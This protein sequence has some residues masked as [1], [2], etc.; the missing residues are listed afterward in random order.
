[1]RAGIGRWLTPPDVAAVVQRWWERGDLARAH[2]TDSWQPRS[3]SL[4]SPTLDELTENFAAVAEWASMWSVP[5]PTV[6]GAIEQVHLGGR[7]TGANTLPARVR[8][9][10]LIEATDQISRTPDL[11]RLRH[12]YD[13]TRNPDLAAWIVAHPMDTLAH[14]DHWTA[15]LDTVEWVANHA[16]P[17]TYLRQITIPGAD[18]KFVERNAA[19]IARLL[20]TVLPEDRVDRAHGPAEF[21]ARYR[22]ATK[23]PTIRF[24]PL[25]PIPGWSSALTDCA[26]P[27]RDFIALDLPITRAYIVENEATYLAFPARP[28]AI[29]I[30]GL[31]YAAAVPAN[32]WLNDRTTHYWGDLDTHGFAILNRI[33][34]RLPDVQSMLM[35]ADTL[36]AYRRH[37]SSEQHPTSDPLPNLTDAERETYVGLAENRWGPAVRLEQERIPL[38]ALTI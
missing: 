24:R 16:T 34:S 1:V 6:T 33:R 30:W 10:Q 28:A 36:H 31:G 4:R 20:D 38:T 5:T 11:A 21:A 7:R 3:V 29:A 18:T 2:L 23:P 12:A 27:A 32:S 17:T 15:V 26:I 19:V 25:G 22:L 35:D 14:A 37:W 13:V 9:D 8:Y